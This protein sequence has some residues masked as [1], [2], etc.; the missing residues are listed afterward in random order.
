VTV[1]GRQLAGLVVGLSISDNEDSA[2]RGFPAWQVNRLTVQVV[3]ALF[4]QGVGVVFGHDWRDDGIMEAIHGFAFQ[5][6]SAPISGGDGA[7]EQRRPLLQNLVPWPDK[8]MLAEEERARLAST[9]Y[10]QRAGVPEELEGVAMQA[11]D[12]SPEDP[13]RQYVRS[14]AL[15][16]L[17]HELVRRSDAR[18]CVGGRRS[19][20]EGRYPGVI[21]EALLSITSGQPLFLAGLLGGAARQLIDAVEGR[22]LPGDFCAGSFAAVSYADCPPEAIERDPGTAADREIDRARVWSAFSG[23]GITGLSGANRLTLDENRELFHTPSI[24]RAVHLVLTGLSRQQAR[25]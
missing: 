15:T 16:H 7:V 23:L 22:D 12:R 24:D 3:A 1:P 6:Q 4:G 2:G 14:R 20:S 25:R 8:L 13:I 21:E 10:V 18:F 17:R 19:G 11:A 9:L 5:M